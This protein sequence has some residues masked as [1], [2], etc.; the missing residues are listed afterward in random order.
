MK[1]KKPAQHQEQVRMLCR[2]WTAPREEIF[3]LLVQRRRQHLSAK[4]IYVL[5]QPAGHDIGIATI[6]RTLDLLD[7]A[8]LLRKIQC[9]GGQVRYQYKRSDQSDHQYH[10]ICTVCGKVLNFRDF[11]KEE[12]DLLGKTEDLLERKSGFLIRDHNIEY[13]GLCKKCRPDGA[14][15]LTEKELSEF[16]PGRSPAGLKAGPLP[17]KEIT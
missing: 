1:S 10:L 6:Y 3:R 17:G 2:R 7:K 5:L 16:G 4:E 9:P 11:E 12:L 8:G 14:R 15:I 13:F